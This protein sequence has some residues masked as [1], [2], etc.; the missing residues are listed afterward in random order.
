VIQAEVTGQVFGV[1]TVATAADVGD[2][3]TMVVEVQLMTCQLMECKLDG[4]WA[5]HPQ[6]S[7]LKVL[8]RLFSSSSLLPPIWLVRNQVISS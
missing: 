7:L 8:A 6:Y 4:T 2:D 1:T 3:S 5:E